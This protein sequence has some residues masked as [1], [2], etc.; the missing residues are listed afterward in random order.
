M[1]LSITAPGASVPELPAYVKNEVPL[2][3]PLNAEGLPQPV[4]EMKLEK[5]E[6]IMVQPQ[7]DH[8]ASMA[9]A[10]IN[11]SDYTYVEYIVAHESSWRVTAQNP[12]GAYGVCQSL[13]AS[14]MATAGADWQTNIVTQLRWCDS[15]AK[16]RYG[17]WAQAYSFWQK[18]RWW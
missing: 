10:G 17:G 14:K 13:P 4:S 3:Q 9:A 12:S 15:Y 11:S 2:L 8:S 7:S 5:Q 1:T 6:P 18:N 16:S